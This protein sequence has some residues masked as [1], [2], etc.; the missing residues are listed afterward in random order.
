RKTKFVHPVK[1]RIRFS[2]D[3]IGSY[4]KYIDGCILEFEASDHV[5]IQLVGSSYFHVRETRLIQHFPRFFGQVGQIS[6]VKTYSLQL[7][8]RFFQFF[9]DFDGVGKAAPECVVRIYQK[10][11]LIRPMTRISSE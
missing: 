4:P 8:A 11:T 9:T 2:Y 7:I 6:A 5:F 10:D 3:E 1:I